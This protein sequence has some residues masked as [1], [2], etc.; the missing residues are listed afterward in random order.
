[1]TPAVEQIYHTLGNYVVRAIP[2]DWAVAWVIAEIE[3]EHSGI[4]F[5]RYKK[6]LEPNQRL[7]NF[8][9]DR[10]VYAAFDQMRGLLRTE[11]KDP[12]TRAIFTLLPSGR[13]RIELEYG[14][15]EG[16]QVERMLAVEARKNAETAI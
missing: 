4:T 16:T 7:Y 3:D 13:F 10:T 11:G 6:T 14:P 12:W 15:L 9:T 5:G 1:M 2:D 8:H